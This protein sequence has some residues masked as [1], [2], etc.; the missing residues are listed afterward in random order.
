MPIVN[1]TRE[2]IE[3]FARGAP[4]DRPIVMLNLLRFRDVADYPEPR[5]ADVTGREAYSRYGRAVMPLLLEVGGQPLWMGK[6]RASVI[7]PDGES[8]DE[9]LLVHY[10][11][12][13][14]FVRMVT[15]DAYQAIMHHRTAA[16]SDSR[17]IETTAVRIPRLLLS[18]A[19]QA[20]RV[21][22]LIWPRLPR[23]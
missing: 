1:P 11:S 20:T 6:A 14:A 21:K 16:L 9:V 2:H 4:D 23:R 15:S 12:R 17:L 5:P 10:P 8:W 22:A 18:V 13:S 7:A 3:R 19:R